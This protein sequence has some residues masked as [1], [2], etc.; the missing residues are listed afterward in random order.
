MKMHG[1][2]DGPYW[3]ISY[4]YFLSISL[5]YMLVFIIFG[6]IIGNIPLICALF[7]YLIFQLLMELY[8]RVEILHIE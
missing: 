1:L 6:S 7:F 5:M 4:T 3:M 2:G 8:Y